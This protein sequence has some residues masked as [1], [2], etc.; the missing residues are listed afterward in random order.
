MFIIQLRILVVFTPRF[1]HVLNKGFCNAKF[2]NLE[3]SGL[4]NIIG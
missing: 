2:W 4:G 3:V 1:M